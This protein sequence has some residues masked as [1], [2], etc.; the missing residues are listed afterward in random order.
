VVVGSGFGGS[1]ATYRLAADGR[2]VLLLERGRRYPPGAFARTPS[3]LA[4]AFWDPSEGLQG[5]FDV[6]SFAGIDGIVSAGLGGGSLIYANVLLRKDEK[7]FVRDAPVDGDGY[8]SW[9]ITRADLDPHYDAVE[10]MIGVQ[11][12]PMNTPGYGISGKT[13]AMQTAAAGLGLEWQLPNLAV[14]FAPD[15]SGT[16]QTGTEIPPPPYGNIHGRMRQTC[17]LCGECDIGC[18]YGSKNTL[19]HTY[20]SAAAA[21]S[22]DISDRCEVR[23]FSSLPGGGYEVQY[24][25]HLPENEG[26]RTDTRSLPKVTVTCDTLVLAAGTFGTSYLLLQNSEALGG[27]SPRLGHRFCGNGDLLGFM[28]GARQ[29]GAPWRLGSTRAPV[30]TTAT[31]VPDAV[32][33]TAGVSGRGFYIEDAGYPGFVDYLLEAADLPADARRALTF[34]TDRLRASLGRVRHTEV[35][36][37]VH[38]LIGDGHVSASA[39]ALLGMGRDTPDGVMTVTDGR[40]EVQWSTRGS[41]S[42]YDTVRDTMGEIAG[43]LGAHFVQDPLSHLHRVITVHPLGGAS[44]GNDPTTGVIDAHGEVFGHPGLFVVDGSAMP[45]P[46][47]ANP[48]LTIA[49][50]ADRAADRILSRPRGSRTAP[51]SP[52]I[53]TVTPDIGPAPVPS[54]SGKTSVQF[55][56]DMKGYFTSGETDYAAGYSEGKKAGSPLM[57]HLTIS[58]DDVDAFIADPQHPGRTVGYVDAPTFGGQRPVQSGLFNLFVTET[59]SSR[60]M[61]YRLLFD[62]AAGNPLTLSGF[63]EVRNDP[64]M[65]LWPDTSTLYTTIYAGHIATESDDATATV[66]GAGILHIHL[67]DFAHQLTT[68]RGRGPTPAAGLAGLERFGKLFLGELWDVYGRRMSAGDGDSHDQADGPAAP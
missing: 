2:E 29:D 31:R 9:P 61:L 62:D 22:A 66:V 45:G 47:G 18:N 43:Q 32:D 27:L 55:T 19:D 40:L 60:R 6:W 39:T 26:R 65:D 59:Q 23:S 12:Y 17:R 35:G 10:A 8:E 11:K 24:V 49:A 38:K 21:K 34:A 7:W 48:S 53:A 46:V 30:I 33:G 63:K 36:E 13:T 3:E 37:Q 58:T 5:L 1:V 67:L 20:L 50:F 16:P 57:F 4:T 44:M 68:F 25:Q 54:A 51:S 52:A 14:S 56:E 28:L 64:G 15:A 42:Y 41:S